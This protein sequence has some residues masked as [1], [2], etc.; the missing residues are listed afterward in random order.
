MPRE[1]DFSD[2]F[3]S[4]AEP[5]RAAVDFSVANNQAVAADVVG[6]LFGSDIRHAWVWVS[7]Y[8]KTTT[9]ERASEGMV[10]IQQKAG[11]VWTIETDS[12]Q[13]TFYNSGDPTPTLGVLFS[14]VAGQVKYTSTNFGGASYEENFKFSVMNTSPV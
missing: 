3:E 1:L 7:G 6:L 5:A 9:T 2:G 8:R 10:H 4:S 13:D 11:A 12:N 14:V